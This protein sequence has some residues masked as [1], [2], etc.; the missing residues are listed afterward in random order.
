MYYRAQILVPRFTLSLFLNSIRIENT[1]TE[2]NECQ[3]TFVFIS[4]TYPDPGYTRRL[5]PE[6]HHHIPGEIF[7]DK[8][9]FVFVPCNSCNVS[10][11]KNSITVGRACV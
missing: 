7:A 1:Y 8:K 9:E 6:C 10:V 11:E 4:P 5:S 2:H 3:V